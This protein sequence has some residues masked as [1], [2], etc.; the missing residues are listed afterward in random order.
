MHFLNGLRQESAYNFVVT[1][2]Y[3][4]CLRYEGYEDDAS[5]D[6]WVNFYSDDVHYVGWCASNARPLVP[7]KC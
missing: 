3:G 1:T 7:P 6:F 2:G 4:V 5:H